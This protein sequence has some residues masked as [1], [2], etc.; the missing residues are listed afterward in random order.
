MLLNFVRFNFKSADLEAEERNYFT[1]H[2]ALA[3]GLPGLRFYYTALL[4]APRG[5]K[6]DRRRAAIL[7]FDSADAWAAA[8]RTEAAPALIADTQAHISDIDSRSAEAEVIVPFDSRRAGQPCFIM[9]A[10]FDLA[11]D[12][13]GP[14]AA[15]I[16][17]RD[18]HVA[19]AR[20]LPGLR[21][22]VIGKLA[23]V[24]RDEP[25]RYRLALLTF[26]SLDAFRAAYAS[27]AGQELIED[28]RA[29][30]RNAR[31]FR[32]DARVEV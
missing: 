11:T 9:A 3:K 16:R 8:M 1:N 17:Y 5:E 26:D 24:A 32:L 15:E 2:V 4:T 14:G 19:I 6:P 25:S 30:I 13:G 23:A 22:Y 20:R 29:T 18:K 27:P 21:N 7:A 12:G 31:V 28:E 10:E